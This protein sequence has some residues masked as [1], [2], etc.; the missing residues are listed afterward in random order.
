M[1]DMAID[2]NEFPKLIIDTED[3]TSVNSVDKRLEEISKKVLEDEG[4][5]G[6][7]G[8]EF[9]DA[10]LNPVVANAIQSAKNQIIGLGLNGVNTPPAKQETKNVKEKENVIIKVQK[11][12]DSDV[13]IPQKVSKDSV[14]Y[15]IFVDLTGTPYGKELYINK[16]A[17]RSIPTNLRFQAPKGFDIQIRPKKGY[18][19]QGTIVHYT[20]ITIDSEY[21]EELFIDVLNL[22]QDSIKIVHG[23]KIAQMVIARVPN[24]KVVLVE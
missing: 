7:P 21:T 5:A 23:Q 9:D 24:S 10:D 6:K 2:E 16:N 14:V 22:S 17:V 19:P 3:D 11:I 13:P 15:D 1:S 4:N 8:G 12:K 20:P 18:T